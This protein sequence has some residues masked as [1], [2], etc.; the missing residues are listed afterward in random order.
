MTLQLNSRTDF[1]IE[2]YAQAAWEGAPVAFSAAALQRMADCRA[3]FMHL[4][5]ND[6]DVTIYGVTSG[7]GQFARVRLKPDERR[8]HAKKPPFGAHAAFGPPLPERVARGIVFARLANYVEGHAAVTPALAQA[9]AQLLDGRRLPPVS[10][11]G[12]GGAG[13]ILGLAPLFSD[14]G[15]NF[16]LAEKES[17][18]LVNGSPCASALVADAVVAMER[19]LPL[20]EQIFALSAEAILSPLTHF[21]PEFEGLWDDPHETAALR[22]LRQL[23]EGGNAER[24]PYQAPVSYRILPRVLAQFRRALA[25]ARDIAER[26]LK[27][28]TDNPVYLPPD[29]EHPHGRVYSTGGYHNAG[30]YPALDGLAAAAADL[31]ILADKHTSKLLDGRYSLLPDQLRNGEGY[32]GCLGMVQVGYA[33]EA[34]RA[35]QRTFLPGSEG[36]GF[37]QNDTAPPTFIAWRGQE[38][39]AYCLEAALA[40]LA[41]VASQALHVTQRTAPPALRNLLADVRRHVPPV[42]ESRA[43]A[44]DMEQLA[45]ALRSGI[46]EPARQAAQ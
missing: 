3:S 5:D 19:R 6:P 2:N 13:E 34:K 29:A 37:G 39:A 44:P 15:A 46:Y 22:S 41:V 35:A 10:A 27:A 42:D 4:I 23:L 7:Y 9:V 28:V 20:I 14:L 18:A 36:G 1:T 11:M 32:L 12:Q 40:A 8:A 38:Q 25:Q 17:L 21:A 33:E 26:S 45:A 31:C 16:D 24:R 43:I 30:A